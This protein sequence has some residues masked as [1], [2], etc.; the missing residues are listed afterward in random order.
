ML[1][2]HTPSCFSWFPCGKFSGSCFQCNFDIVDENP[3]NLRS[4]EHPQRMLVS[5]SCNLT[6]RHS[7]IV[8]TQAPD[9]LKRARLK[10]LLSTRCNVLR[11][12][13]S[14]FGSSRAAAFVIVRAVGPS[15]GK[16]GLLGPVGHRRISSFHRA[17]EVAPPCL[18]GWMQ[19]DRQQDP[20]EHLQDD[21]WYRQ[22]EAEILGC[23]GR[24]CRWNGR[25]CTSW[26]FLTKDERKGRMA[27][28]ML[29]GV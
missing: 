11:Q 14:L 29:W 27:A 23:C 10:S 28:G 26:P 18:P 5:N 15:F 9:S 4:S 22:V 6:I 13:P 20:E 2:H 8:R 19:K 24:S 7:F 21:P 25:S 12:A 1:F 17:P 16:I 3:W